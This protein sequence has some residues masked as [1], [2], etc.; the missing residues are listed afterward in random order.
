MVAIAAEEAEAAA[1]AAVP[2]SS[3]W[4]AGV[5]EKQEQRRGCVVAIDIKGAAEIEAMR[6][7]SLLAA[8]TLRMASTHIKPGINTEQLDRL[9]KEY[10]LDHKAIPAPLNYRG[11]PKS[12]C[13]SINEVVCHGIPSRNEILR[14]GDIVNV[15]VTTILHGFHGDTSRTFYVGTPSE[16]A[17]HVTEVARTSLDLGIQTV[18]P[19]ARIRDIG[20]AI[21]DYAHA[22][23][24]SVVRDYCGHGIGREFHTDPQIAHYRFRGPNPRFRPGMTFTIEPMVNVGT[25]RVRL[26]DDGWTVKTVDGQLSAQFEHTLLV[27]ET[28]V[29]VLTDWARLEGSRYD[30]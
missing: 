12:I 13:T 26:L 10:I 4:A 20:A 30:S 25:W 14:D 2:G 6:E 8:A 3:T 1:A 17:R 11:F 21:E 23:G 7:T 16:S 5:C 19:G 15:D 24:C 18:K 9:C 22:E 28:G 29:E 27:T